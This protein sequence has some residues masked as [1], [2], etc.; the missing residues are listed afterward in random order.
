[1]SFAART[2]AQKSPGWAISY[3]YAAGSFSVA[4]QTADPCGIFFKPDGSKMYVSQRS[5]GYCAEYDLSIDWDITTSVFL[6]SKTFIFNFVQEQIR[7]IFFKYDGTVIYLLDGLRS[8]NTIKA[9][10]LSIA[11]DISSASSSISSVFTVSQDTQTRQFYIT[12]DGLRLFVVGNQNDKIYQYSL[13]SAWDITSASFDSDVS[14]V[15]VAA[16][17]EGV[18]ISP[19]GTQVILTQGSDSFGNPPDRVWQLTMGSPWTITSLG[20]STNN[21]SLLFTPYDNAVRNLYIRQDGS[22]MYVVGD[23]SSSVYQFQL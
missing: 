22:R 11:W 20:V 1:M 14:I 18:T 23:L 21:P 2:M 19:D 13:A 10:D 12:E 9:V 5:S 8:P 15:S 7:S 6:Q 3:A 16:F 4:S 17:P